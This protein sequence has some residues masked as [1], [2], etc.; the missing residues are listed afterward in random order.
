MFAVVQ[1]PGQRWSSALCCV[2]LGV[3]PASLPGPMPPRSTP[4]DPGLSLASL[5]PRSSVRRHV[6]HL[7][8]DPSGGTRFIRPSV[9]PAQRPGWLEVIPLRLAQSPPSALG[10]VDAEARRSSRSDFRAGSGRGTTAASTVSRRRGQRGDATVDRPS[11]RRCIG[12]STGPRCAQ[13]AFNPDRDPSVATAP[14]SR[15]SLRTTPR[16]ARARSHATC[17]RMH[18]CGNPPG[19]DAE[20]QQSGA[21]NCTLSTI[22]DAFV[23]AGG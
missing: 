17:C 16:A 4:T 2:E 11:L 1:S 7:H 22:G 21:L 10:K 23:A 9:P 20:R 12:F 14:V 18:P 5:M 15:R 3:L 8:G 19:S 13:Q 6:S